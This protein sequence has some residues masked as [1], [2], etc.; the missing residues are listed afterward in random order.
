MPAVTATSIENRFAPAPSARAAAPTTDYTQARER[1][2]NRMNVLSRA[3]FAANKRLEAKA[4]ATN[5]GLQIVNFYTIAIGL[6]LLQFPDAS[7]ITGYTRSLNFVSFLA[8]I[9]VQIIALIE[10]FKD[11]SGKARSMHDCA[12]EVSRIHQELE[13]DQRMEWP[14]LMHYQAR[15]H[16]A[17]KDYNVNHDEIDFL[18]AQIEPGRHKD[19]SRNEWKSLIWWR[20]R[21]LWNVYGFTVSILV[22]PWVCMGLLALFNLK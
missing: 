9:F 15:Y 12:L 11:Y 1:L 16:E 13:M 14:L 4:V 18:A 21:F 17:I 5:L 2:I 6:L 22:L 8:S 3:R 20:L 19:R 10:N 7:L